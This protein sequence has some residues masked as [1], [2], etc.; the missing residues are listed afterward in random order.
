M[1]TE[2]RHQAILDIYSAISEAAIA[3]AIQGIRPL[4]INVEEAKTMAITT[5]MLPFTPILNE[6]LRIKP[7]MCFNLDA[8]SCLVGKGGTK[9]EKVRVA[10]FSQSDLKN[11]NLSV[12]VTRNATKERFFKHSIK[13]TLC[14][15]IKD[16]PVLH[17]LIIFFFL[18]LQL[19]L[20]GLI[21]LTLFSSFFFV[22]FF[23]I[24][25]SF[26]FL[27]VVLTTIQRYIF[28]STLKKSGSLILFDFHFTI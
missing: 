6:N 1:K 22:L 19:L 11:K 15:H 5:G 18:L 16:Y 4:E 20:F 26:F 25:I 8:V 9:A 3:F 27:F 28:Y 12:S 17:F 23:F 24:Y 14:L 21:F 7:S 13:L 2:R 10:H